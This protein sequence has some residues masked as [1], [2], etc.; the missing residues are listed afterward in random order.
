MSMVF[1]EWN[2]EELES[3]LVEITRDILAKKDDDG[4]PLVDKIL[5][6]AGQKGTGKWTVISSA[7]LGI[8]ITLIA[9]AV[10]SRCVS[11]MKDQRVEAVEGL[12]GQRHEIPG[13]PPPVGHGHPQGALRLEDHQLHPGLHAD[14]G[15]RP[16]VQVEPELR[17][18]RPDVA[19]RLHHPQ[20]LPRQDQG[21]VRQESRTSR[22]SCSIRSSRRR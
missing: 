6:T 13:R 22:T 9:E 5:D 1:A 14:A 2:K 4:Q 17:R 10:Y 16:A 7:D 8:P 18:H 21:G 3:Y 19:R 15:R 12:P 20:R 11:A